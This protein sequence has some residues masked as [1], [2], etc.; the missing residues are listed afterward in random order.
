MRGFAGLVAMA[1][2]MALAP[3][4]ALADTLYVGKSGQGR[5][6]KLR[7]GD[8][9]RVERFAIKWVADCRRPGYVFTSGTQTTPRSP[10]EVHTRERFVDVGAYRERLGD[11]SRAVYEGRTVG[12]RVSERRWRGIFRIRVR[13]LRGSRL[14]DRCYLRTRWRV[15]ARR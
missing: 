14:V 7:T 5:I 1:G 12:N 11:G 9:G 2:L 6:A 3:A 8:D 4:D 15:L 10:F 13:V